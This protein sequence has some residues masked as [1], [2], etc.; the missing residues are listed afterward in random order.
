M[1]LEIQFRHMDRS[2]ALEDSVTEKVTHAVEGF[3]HKHDAHVQV[4]LISDL[5]RTTRGT[6]VF[7]CEIEVRCPKKKDYF[8]SKVDSDMYMAIQDA[9]DKLKVLLDEAGKREIQ[10]RTQIPADILEGPVYTTEPA[11]DEVMGTYGHQS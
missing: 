6:G 9:T 4:W 5:N 11:E 8:I 2:E 7:K 10:Q 3:A 1:R